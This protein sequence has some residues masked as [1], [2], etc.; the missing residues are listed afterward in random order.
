MFNPETRRLRRQS[1]E[2]L[3][4]AIGGLPGFSAE[5]AAAMVAGV[6]VSGS[7]TN[8]TS[9]DPDSY[10]GFSAKIEDFTYKYLGEKEMLACV[11]AKFSPEAAMPH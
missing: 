4:D 8:V 11:H 6:G 7:S 5:G 2:I 9:L 1:P 10:F 3:A